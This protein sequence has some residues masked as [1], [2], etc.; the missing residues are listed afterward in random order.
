MNKY[1]EVQLV[2]DREP[3]ERVLL[4]LSPDAAVC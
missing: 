1:G 3:C 2:D 4:A